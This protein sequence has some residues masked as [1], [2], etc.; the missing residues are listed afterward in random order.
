MVSCLM[1]SHVRISVLTLV[2]SVSIPHRL[3]QDFTEFPVWFPLGFHGNRCG[4]HRGVWTQAG[5]CGLNYAE[6]SSVRTHTHTHLTAT[7]SGT[8]VSTLWSET[9]CSGQRCGFSCARV[10]TRHKPKE[11]VEPCMWFQRS[12][13]HVLVKLPWKLLSAERHTQ[14]ER[15]QRS[16]LSAF[17]TEV[18]M[19]HI[20]TLRKYFKLHLQRVFSIGTNCFHHAKLLQMSR[21]EMLTCLQTQT[22]SH[23]RRVLIYSLK[24]RESGEGRKRRRSMMAI[25]ARHCELHGLGF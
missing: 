17:E 23:M 8:T 20:G 25:A 19:K 4:V 22:L 12:N 14:R 24:K 2:Y 11:Q 18:W 5:V 21:L 9:S 10:W 16:L 6:N 3:F 7:C 13:E 15:D 1:W